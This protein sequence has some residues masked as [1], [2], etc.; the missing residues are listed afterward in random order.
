M[1]MIKSFFYQRT[2]MVLYYFIAS[3]V[4]FTVCFVLKCIAI[5]I[6]DFRH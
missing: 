5:F 6:G 4:N 1:R 2:Y 3:L